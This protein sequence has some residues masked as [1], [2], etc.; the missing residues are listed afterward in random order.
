YGDGQDPTGATANEPLVA[1]FLVAHGYAVLG[2]NVRGTGC[3]GGQFIVL[4]P[5]WARDGSRVVEWAATQN[6]SD[7]NVGMFGFSFP[8]IAALLTAAAHPAHLKAIAPMQVTADFYRD[9]LAPGGIFNAG[10]APAWTAILAAQGDPPASSTQGGD[11][12]CVAN[13]AAS[14][15]VNPATAPAVEL[16]KHK[17]DD[18]W[19]RARSPIAVVS[20][21]HV[22]VLTGAAWQDDALSGREGSFYWDALDPA[23]TWVLESNGYH[24]VFEIVRSP[25]FEKLLAFF[26][27]FVRGEPN[28]F[29][30]TPHFELWHESVADSACSTTTP[31]WVSKVATRPAVEPRAFYLDAGGAL[32]ASA[33][34]GR[35]DRYAYPG[36]SAFEETGLLPGMCETVND[37]TWKPP[38]AAGTFAAYTS[39]PFTS[40]T[41]LFGTASLDLW[42]SSTARDTD[43]Q[44]TLTDV[45]ADGQ[46]MFV[47]RGWL[48]AS[49]RALDAANSTELRPYQAHL[50]SDAQPLTPGE[51]T[52]MRVEIFPF[53]HVFR[54][55]SRLRVTIDAPTGAGDV[56]R[57]DFVKDPAVNA[58]FHDAAHPSR[59]V[60][61]VLDANASAPPLGACGAVLSQPCR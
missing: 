12:E 53:D 8:G 38:D 21:I 60:V 39:A 52:P 16:P 55:G 1:S 59:L 58:V 2:V 44:A 17:F 11:S 54:A 31:G 15:L 40:A 47:A 14:A 37:V 10:F 43:L 56:W 61:G 26:D 13:M 45:R 7:G 49:H 51:P 24:G 50:A 27:H 25:Y 22:P 42:L 41:E 35:P 9:S 30:A 23:T 3:S 46:E 29:D 57:F 20:Q 34:W 36:V 28:G 5:Q 18:A 32:D 6:W 19:M 48:R 4:D 33:G